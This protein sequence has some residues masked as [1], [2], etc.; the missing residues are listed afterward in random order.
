ML[1]AAFLLFTLFSSAQAAK[2]DLA[3]C[4]LTIVPLL[5]EIVTT[6]ADGVVGSYG[7]YAETTFMWDGTEQ[8]QLLDCGGGLAPPK[9]DA[10]GCPLYTGTDTVPSIPFPT[11]SLT[12]QALVTPAPT[13]TPTSASPVPASPP[14]S[15]PATSSSVS[16]SAA[17]TPDSSPVP[18]GATSPAP[19]SAAGSPTITTSAIQASDLNPTTTSGT[20]TVVPNDAVRIY[21]SWYLIYSGFTTAMIMFVTHLL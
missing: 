19:A 10:P 16:S 2:T 5:T 1:K 14:A 12:L 18:G 3:G 15:M 7:N 20:P 21:G 9:T 11:A 17:A 6:T 13:S 8:C 4:T